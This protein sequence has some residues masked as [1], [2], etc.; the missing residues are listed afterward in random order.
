MPPYPQWTYPAPTQG[1]G[2]APSPL[3]AAISPAA[4]I[5]RMV[6]GVGQTSPGGGAVPLDTTAS[7]GLGLLLVALTGV[8]SYYAGSA[9]A[10]SGSK[11]KTWGII[12]IPVGMLTGAW[13]LG[14]MGIVARRK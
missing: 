10:P 9:M 3:V 14:V 11:E 5:S 2:A 13:G 8:F 7:V 1:A 4:A 6:S 12:G